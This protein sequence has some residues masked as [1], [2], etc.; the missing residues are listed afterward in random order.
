MNY[1]KLA[2]L[3]CGLFAGL[4]LAQVPVKADEFCIG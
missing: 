3:A 2:L 1:R 4:L